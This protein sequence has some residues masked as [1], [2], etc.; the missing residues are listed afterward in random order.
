MVTAQHSALLAV[1][2]IEEELARK[3]IDISSRLVTYR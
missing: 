1:I 3:A 2:S